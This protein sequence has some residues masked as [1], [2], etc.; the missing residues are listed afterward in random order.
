MDAGGGRSHSRSSEVQH[1]LRMR[2]ETSANSR[3]SRRAEEEDP[4]PSTTEPTGPRAPIPIRSPGGDFRTNMVFL[5]RPSGSVA[6]TPLTTE[7]F[8]RAR[9]EHSAPRRLA[10]STPRS[11]IFVSPAGASS[12]L[13]STV[14]GS[15][16][17]SRNS[18]ETRGGA[19]EVDADA[20]GEAEPANAPRGGRRSSA[21]L[22]TIESRPNASTSASSSATSSVRSRRRTMP[23]IPPSSVCT[24]ASTARLARRP[25][26]I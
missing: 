7:M 11:S 6:M 9:E 24:R 18:R 19:V 26:R 21:L 1:A 20:A 22:R 2:R 4:G 14:N 5:T 23:V 25:A 16:A 10:R 8:A 3:S 15:P 12:L 17:A 13:S